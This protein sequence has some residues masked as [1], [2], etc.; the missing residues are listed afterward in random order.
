M[1]KTF[2]LNKLFDFHLDPPSSEN[3]SLCRIMQDGKDPIIT[4]DFYPTNVEPREW[5]LPTP[6]TNN[7]VTTSNAAVAASNPPPEIPADPLQP[8]EIQLHSWQL[9]TREAPVFDL[10]GKKVTST[11][12]L[13]D[14]FC[15][16]CLCSTDSDQQEESS[17]NGRRKIQKTHKSK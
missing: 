10:R 2:D 11:L 1:L 17:T 7:E 14:A 4:T 8:G 5:I 3:L 6:P 9:Y 13:A 15:E 12:D 16:L